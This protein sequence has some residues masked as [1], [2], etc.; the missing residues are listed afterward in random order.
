MVKEKTWRDR[1]YIIQY[2]KRY[3]AISS[4]YIVIV[5]VLRHLTFAMSLDSVS[6]DHLGLC[7]L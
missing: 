5:I 2:M 7:F 3:I 1:H 4:S 6:Q